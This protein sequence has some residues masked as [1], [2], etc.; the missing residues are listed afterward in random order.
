[1]QQPLQLISTSRHQSLAV[2]AIKYDINVQSYGSGWTCHTAN[3]S[4]V[5]KGK[6]FPY[7]LPSIRPGADPGVQAVS[8]HVTISLPPGSKLQLLSARPAVT[9]PATE[10]HC[11]L[12]GTKLYC[13]VTDAH[14]CKQ[15]DQGCYAAFARAEFEPTTCWSQVQRSTCC[16]TAPPHWIVLMWHIRAD[17]V[18]KYTYIKC[19]HCELTKAQVG[20]LTTNADVCIQSNHQS[21]SSAFVCIRLNTSP[22]LSGHPL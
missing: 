21:P 17:K 20:N 3:G 15:L 4:Q 12:A 16:A 18:H 22:A 13:L 6:R 5:K 14:R 9:F 8:L 7:S 19:R 10:H 2:R 1:M 11:P